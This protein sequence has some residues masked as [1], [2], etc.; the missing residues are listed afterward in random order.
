MSNQI[1]DKSTIAR[2][3]NSLIINLITINNFFKFH[4][5]H[6]IGVAGKKHVRNV[7]LPKFIFNII[8]SIKDISIPEEINKQNNSTATIT[9]TYLIGLIFLQKSDQI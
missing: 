5:F 1:L 4:L 2:T 6:L 8:F 3:L 9:M 7:F